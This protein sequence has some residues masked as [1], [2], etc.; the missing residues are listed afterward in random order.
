MESFYKYGTLTMT[1]SEPNSII[2]DGHK[3]FTVF[4]TIYSRKILFFF[5]QLYETYF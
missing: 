4:Y 5:N 1:G 3:T 2:N